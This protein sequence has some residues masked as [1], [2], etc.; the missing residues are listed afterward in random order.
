MKAKSC[1][2]KKTKEIDQLHPVPLFSSESEILEVCE[3][4]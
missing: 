4:Y 1:D 3:L 2:L